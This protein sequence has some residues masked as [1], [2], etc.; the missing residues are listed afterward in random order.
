MKV[1]FLTNS[2]YESTLPLIKNLKTKHDVTLLCVQTINNLNPPEFNF[3]FLSKEP[4]SIFI[5]DTSGCDIPSNVKNY[6]NDTNFIKILFLKNKSDIPWGI[7]KIMRFSRANKFDV[8]HFIGINLFSMLL[9]LTFY[10]KNKIFSIHEY[11]MNRVYSKEKIIKRL[12]TKSM[13]ILVYHFLSKKFIFFSPNELNKASNKI[14]LFKKNL[15]KLIP[16][17]PFETYY[18]HPKKRLKIFKKNS[19][20]LFLGSP[21]KYKGYDT[22]IKISKDKRL[23]N[24]NFIIAGN[25]V[26]KYKTENETKNIKFID[27]FLSGSEI[28]FLVSNSLA[29]ILPYTSA[30]QSGIP[31][32]AFAL[33]TPIIS[34]KIKSLQFYT[35]EKY[36]SIYF[37]GSS[38]DIIKIILDS[39]QIKNLIKMKNKIKVSAYK[40]KVIFDWN[41]IGNSV[42]SFYQ[43]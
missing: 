24:Y 31:S 16:F 25:G 15:I 43:E 13:E 9:S 5:E 19:Y 40:K 23:S 32:T 12:A 41:Y 37:D 20:F 21:K 34:T 17:G 6:F 28:A 26:S 18:H 4:H 7:S 36:N 27:R 8:F 35:E 39:S 29:C 3:N 1:L 14:Y 22:F 10:S 33:G 2:F 42:S 11:S 38:E 30:S